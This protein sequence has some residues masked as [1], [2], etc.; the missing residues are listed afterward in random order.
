M[1]Q[2]RKIYCL[3]ARPCIFQPGHFVAVQGLRFLAMTSPGMEMEL[4]KISGYGVP[5]N[6][7]EVYDFWL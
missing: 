1:L 6:G 2:E 7:N 5:E 4:I 3:Q